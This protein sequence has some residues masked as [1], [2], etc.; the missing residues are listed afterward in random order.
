MK[1]GPVDEMPPPL[2]CRILA[3]AI[4]QPRDDFR[5][6]GQFSW[7]FG[8][9]NDS[10]LSSG[11]EIIPPFFDKEFIIPSNHIAP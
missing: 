4:L 1:H 3:R 6:V 8:S 11:S 10:N 2:P 7:E 9:I 5:G